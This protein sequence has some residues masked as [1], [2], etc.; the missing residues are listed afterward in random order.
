MEQIKNIN[1]K[2]KKNFYN[3][4]VQATLI[5]LVTMIIFSGA[6]FLF[7]WTNRVDILNFLVKE[8]RASQKDFSSVSIPFIEE[9]EEEKIVEA[10]SLVANQIVPE[11]KTKE[12]EAPTVV[13]AVKKAKPAVI[14]II[15]TKTDGGKQIGSGSGFLISPDGLIV[16]NRHVVY[17]DDVIFN[18]L[19]ND[20]REYKAK[21][22]DR[23][24]VLDI[25][26]I[27]IEDNNLPY[28]TLA[29]SDLLEVGETVI[30]IGNAL[31]EFKNTV[32]AGVI[33]GLSRSLTAG[34]N[35]GQKEYLDKVIQTDAAINKGNSGGPLLNIYGEVV[36][37][38]VAVVENSSSIGFSLPIN[39]VKD[40][41]ESVRKT[42]R[43]I[44]PYIGIRYVFIT[45]NVKT[46]YDLPYDYG[47]FIQKGQ[48]E[49][50]LAILSGSPAEKAGLQE[51]DIILE[52]DGQKIDSDRVLSYVIRNKKIGDFLSMRVY[53]KGLIK[54]IVVILEQA[55]LGL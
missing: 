32:S 9:K 15:I 29:D 34:D 11:E 31:G 54:T 21:V 33:S 10:E 3:N 20:G 47:V 22:L 1:S 25:A 51:G 37:I 43:I 53:S 19:L 17:Q 48:T 6:V 4:I 2:I 23:D 40:V 35:F 24:P 13:S 46:I 39:S 16:T 18:V 26:L 41:I 50:D 44:R 55:P 38:N 5:S 28:L 14:S 8:Y 36:G 27:K 49:D 30:A 12:E 45:P 7:A 52:V 42:G